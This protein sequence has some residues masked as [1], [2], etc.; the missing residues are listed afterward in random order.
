MQ[1]PWVCIYGR[2][3]GRKNLP[4]HLQI[5][6][7]MFTQNLYWMKA[8]RANFKIELKMD[9]ALGD[10]ETK[11]IMQTILNRHAE[12]LFAEVVMLS[13]KRRPMVAVISDDEAIE[14]GI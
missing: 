4:N 5:T 11:A 7:H 10:E 14:I 1:S 8:M 13:D 2:G 3:A 9:I 6:A 12:E